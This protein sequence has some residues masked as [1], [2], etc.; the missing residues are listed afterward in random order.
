L[1]RRLLL[2]LL[3]LSVSITAIGAILRVGSRL[4]Q[5]AES[6]A[7]NTTAAPAGSSPLGIAPAAHVDGRSRGTLGRLVANLTEPLPL[8]LLQVVVIV[9]AARLVGTLFHRLGQPAVVGE[10]V[11]GILLGPSLLGWLWPA[12]QAFLFPPASLGPLRLLSQ[13][14]VILFMLVVGIDLD[15]AHLRQR[16]RAA[17]AVSHASIQAPMLL[18][19]AFALLVYERFAGPGTRFTP[20]ALFLGVAMS[21]TAF[22]V[23][24][25]IIDERGLAG[26]PLGAAAI[27]CAAV[28]DVTAWCLLALVVTLAKAEALAGAAVTVLLTLAFV[29]LTLGVARPLA[30][31]L[32]PAEVLRG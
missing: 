2:Y 1:L 8:L 21:I 23:L 18:G 15:V 19:T 28:D 27:A 3:V 25:R 13:I 4:P 32:V 26:T 7:A 16:A 24:A 11:A 17:V 14:G 12:A 9:V 20:F 5:P 6:A 31:R 30:R 10:M 22:P 29:A